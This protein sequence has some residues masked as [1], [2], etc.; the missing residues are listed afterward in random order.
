MLCDTPLYHRHVNKDQRVVEERHVKR[1]H[2]VYSLQNATQAFKVT[3]MKKRNHL[4]VPLFPS[5]WITP[6]CLL[7]P[8]FFPPI[9][10]FVSHS[11]TSPCVVSL[12][13][14]QTACKCSNPEKSPGAPVIGC[15]L[16]HS[17]Q[18]IKARW[19]PV[20]SFSLL[21]PWLWYSHIDFRFALNPST[22]V[23]LSFTFSLYIFPFHFQ[24]LSTPSLNCH[25]KGFLPTFC[26]KMILIV[27]WLRAST[28]L[29][30]SCRLTLK[31]DVFQRE[32]AKDRKINA[33]HDN[34]AK[35]CYLICSLWW[36]VTLDLA[37]WA[38]RLCERT[39]VHL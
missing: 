38:T 39:E 31:S 34:R 11:L 25:S 7:I 33:V 15:V 17:S 4:E 29:T 36:S 28:I 35:S 1:T 10:L 2:D 19:A 14:L 22:A 12:I 23:L 5:P 3:K 27:K 21:L 26:F 20:N 30:L 18:S 32:R 6:P 24:Q 8:L 9:S 13:R 37:S 16:Q